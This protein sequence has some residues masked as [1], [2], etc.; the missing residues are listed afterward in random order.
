MQA[1]P[2]DRSSTRGLRIDAAFPPYLL[3]FAADQ[4]RYGPFPPLAQKQREM[5]DKRKADLAANKSPVAA[6][7]ASAATG[8]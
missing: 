4:H 6:A 7:P 8:P 1:H 2:V 5:A 3:G